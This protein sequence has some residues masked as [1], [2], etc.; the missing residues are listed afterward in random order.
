[1]EITRINER[2]G[3]IAGDNSIGF[4]LGFE[5]RMIIVCGFIGCRVIVGL[6]KCLLLRSFRVFR[7]AFY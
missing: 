2:S 6:Y 5:M 1:M 7:E 4:V 3:E